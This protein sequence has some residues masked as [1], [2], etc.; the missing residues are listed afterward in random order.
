MNV[1]HYI[2]VCFPICVRSTLSWWKRYDMPRSVEDRN[3]TQLIPRTQTQNKTMY[4]LQKFTHAVCRDFF[5]LFELIN[6]IRKKNVFNIFAQ[7]LMCSNH[8]VEAILTSTHNLCFG[9]K[10][11]KPGIPLQTQVFLYKSGVLG[12]MLF[13]DM[14]S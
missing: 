11:R 2:P 8:L 5:Q 10:I 1:L 9:A 14:L 13:M 4:A 12:G 7:I 6:F 3:Q